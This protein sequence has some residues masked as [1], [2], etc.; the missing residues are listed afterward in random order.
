M[1]ESRE[2]TKALLKIFQ[3]EH[4]SPK[5]RNT[6][7]VWIVDL[8]HHFFKMGFNKK[9]I[10]YTIPSTFLLCDIQAIVGF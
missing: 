7:M 4:V 9:G 3:V 2:R 10:R 5:D 6:V 1:M 8:S